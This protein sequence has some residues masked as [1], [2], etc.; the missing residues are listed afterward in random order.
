MI[1][2][3]FTRPQKFKLFSYLIRKFEKTEY[4]HCALIFYSSSLGR[5][6]V[7]EASILGVRFLSIQKFNSLNKTIHK[8]DYDVRS[9]IKNKILANCVDYAGTGYGYLSILGIGIFKILNAIGIK[10]KKPFFSDGDKTFY[11]NELVWHLIESHSKNESDV[12][13]QYGL[14]ISLK[15]LCDYA[16]ALEF[17]KKSK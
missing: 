1:T 9:S 16:R 15:E 7:Y 8:F 6:L 10:Q 11:C 13:I 3:V 2:L 12:K 4:S 14:D 5:Q 17:V